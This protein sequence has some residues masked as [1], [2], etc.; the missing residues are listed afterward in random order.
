MRSKKVYKPEIDPRK[1]DRRRG[2]QGSAT[3]ICVL[4]LGLLSIFVAVALSRTTTEAII[5]GNDAAESRSFYAS[6]AS[7]ETMTR[8]FNKVFDVR[9][10]PSPQ[11]LT[12][13][14]TNTPTMPGFTF[15]QQITQTGTA[16][17]TVLAGG[18]FEGLNALRD[19][20][21]L[22]TTATGPTGVQVQLARTYFNY[23]VPIF[24]FGIFYDDN[25]EF[26][27]GPGLRFGG[28]VHTNG[29]LFVGSWG[30]IYFNS[31]V[32]ASRE[33][34]SDVLRNGQGTT[35]YDEVY[36]KNG[37]NA[38]VKI[39]RGRGSAT[40]GPDFNTSDADMP[41]GSRNTNW[42]TI[43]AEFD[44]NLL[45]S[46]KPLQLPLKISNASNIEIIKRGRN[47]NDYEVTTQ[48]R[49]VDDQIIGSS[50]YANQPGIRI[51]LADSQAELP[52]GT[53]GIRLDGA[54]DGLGGASGSRGSSGNGSRGYQ[55]KAMTDYQATRFNAYR[56]YTGASYTDRSMPAA[57]QTWIKVEIVKINAATLLVETQD[58]TEDFLSLGLTEQAP[59]RVGNLFE[60]DDDYYDDG[61]D[62]RSIIKMQRYTV[63]NIS[64]P[65]IKANDSGQPAYTPGPDSKPVYTFVD[66]DPNPAV[67]NGYSCV[68]NDNYL[69]P[70]EANFHGIEAEINDEDENSNGDDLKIV[71]FPIE[72]FD[73][74]EGISRFDL[75]GNYLTTNYPTGTIPW[76]GVMSLIDID[77]TNFRRF[78]DGEFNGK[79][80]SNAALP[81]GSLSNDDV[82]SDN[83]GRLIYVSDRRGDRDFDGEYDM[84]D[85]YGPNDGNLQP[86]EDVNGDTILNVD[87]QWEGSKYLAQASWLLAD[88]PL[89]IT[90]SATTYTDLAAFFD[91]RYY[92]RGV[93]LI[94]GTRLPGNSTT[95]LTLASENG[96]YILGNYNATGIRQ[97]GNPLGV[98][99]D[100][101]PAEDFLP[102]ASNGQVPASVVAD[103]V[104]ILSNA[105]NDGK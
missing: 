84:E 55:P 93:R 27:V 87:N 11:D 23:R 69:I 58:A 95:G 1:R 49:A 105:W 96:V 17:T 20:W 67:Y 43:K 51:T 81:G 15:N 57:R 83:P 59:P 28:R 9:L 30:G 62:S 36:V 91:H 71:P 29:N 89:P 48:G 102:D 74:R 39:G 18:P 40:D 5:M 10:N 77:V 61:I 82:P 2:E 100:P 37:T 21:R 33:I 79:F 47:A 45:D 65:P 46:A 35:G 80:P 42:N 56:L 99:G 25:L 32:S 53:G 38:Y 31:R 8:S 4:I 64:A 70:G 76:N 68:T 75:Y 24:Q 97:V 12:N 3:V 6:Q 66:L 78:V 26:T 52:S 50:R 94:N 41:D 88:A 7:L 98:A 34:V 14:Q 103:A 22:T 63:S 92:R 19:P 54:G 85:I 90:N 44:N 13:I 86:G 101:T 16:E 73:G 60:P 72:M 104:T